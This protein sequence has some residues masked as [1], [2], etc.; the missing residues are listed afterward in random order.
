MSSPATIIIYIIKDRKI[1]IVSNQVV[2]SVFK[3]AWLNLIFKINIHHGRLIV[4][5]L[6]EVWH[7]FNFL[8]KIL[9]YQKKIGDYLFFYSLNASHL[10]STTVF[11]PGHTPPLASRVNGT[12]PQPMP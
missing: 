3:S 12:S 5:V 4:I 2:N 1:K 11:A 9:F 6:F 8:L 10:K 7:P